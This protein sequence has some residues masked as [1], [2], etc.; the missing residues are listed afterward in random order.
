MTHSITLLESL[1]EAFTQTLKAAGEDLSE[2]EKDSFEYDV[3]QVEEAIKQALAY[4]AQ[5][6]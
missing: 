1:G 5:V 4:L 6:S 3:R 2:V